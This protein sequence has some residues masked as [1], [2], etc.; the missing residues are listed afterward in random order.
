MIPVNIFGLFLDLKV[1][2]DQMDNWNDSIETEFEYFLF[3]KIF[4]KN[5]LKESVSHKL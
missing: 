4:R 5:L 2:C 1:P 3:R